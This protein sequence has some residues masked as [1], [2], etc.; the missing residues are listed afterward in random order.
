MATFTPT[1]QKS[2]GRCKQT[3]DLD[4]F[5]R[6]KHTKSGRVSHCRACCKA[7][8]KEGAEVYRN[9]TLVRIYGITLA[10]Y[11]E[12][13][14]AQCGACA[15]CGRPETAMGSGGVVKRLAIDHD[16][17]TGAVR[18]LLCTKCNVALGAADDSMDRLLA[19]VSY[20]REHSNGNV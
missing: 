7:R 15:I 3:K 17:T 14:V 1:P 9:T 8:E 10:D 19:M 4:G 20:L 6:S 2:C 11:N 18:A 12:M 5:H 13:V 16:H